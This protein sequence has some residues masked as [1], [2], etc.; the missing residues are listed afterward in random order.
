[1]S[2]WVVKVNSVGDSCNCTLVPPWPSSI[3]WTALCKTQRD[4]LRSRVHWP[5][6]DRGRL[7]RLTLMA[8]DAGVVTGAAGSWA[9][10]AVFVAARATESAGLVGLAFFSGSGA[11]STGLGSGL[12]GAGC[13]VAGVFA[14][15]CGTGL[16]TATPWLAGVVCAAGLGVGCGGGCG[17]GVGVGCCGFAAGTDCVVAAGGVAVAAGGFSRSGGATLM[18]AGGW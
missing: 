5:W 3:F 13:R 8:S 6:I 4:S 2:D 1:M 16:A 11:V 12:A 18:P 17:V 10:G 15:V 9:T 14:A 7:S